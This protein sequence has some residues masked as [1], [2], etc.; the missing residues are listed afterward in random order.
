MA[1]SGWLRTAALGAA[2][3]GVLAGCQINAQYAANCATSPSVP[4]ENPGVVDVSIDIPLSV[5]PSQTFEVT[6]FNLDASNGTTGQYRG[7]SITVTG[8]VYPSGNIPIGSR[9]E[10][11]YPQTLMFKATGQP[12]EVIHFN[13]EDGF[14]I[15]GDVLTNAYGLSCDPGSPEIGTTTITAPGA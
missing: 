4:Q 10:I 9:A 1:V 6:V 2:A 3:G 11:P 5:E 12:G 14:A 8:P 13:A 7:G 15:Y